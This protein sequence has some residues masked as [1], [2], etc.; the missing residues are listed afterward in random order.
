MAT[1]ELTLD[2]Q[3]QL[4]FTEAYAR[5]RAEGIGVQTDFPTTADKISAI[6]IPDPRKFLCPIY[7]ANRDKI[8]QWLQEKLGAA[9]AMVICAALDSLCP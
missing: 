8:R 1:R 6:A 4:L 2:E 7:K 9:A 5:T 3:M